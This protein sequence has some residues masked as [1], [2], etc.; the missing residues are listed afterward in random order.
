MQPNHTTYTTRHPITGPQSLAEDFLAHGEG[1]Q[2]QLASLARAFVLRPIWEAGQRAEDE[3]TAQYPYTQEEIL[4]LCGLM[5][6][7]PSPANVARAKV[8]QAVRGEAQR[9]SAARGTITETDGLLSVTIYDTVGGEAC[10]SGE[11]AA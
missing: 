4:T 3:A 9:L 1:T 10:L 8:R 6:G 5:D 7:E 11:V 2:R